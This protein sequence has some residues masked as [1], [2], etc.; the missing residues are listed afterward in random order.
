[1]LGFTDTKPLEPF[2]DLLKEAKEQAD[3]CREDHP[4]AVEK[5]AQLNQMTAEIR[6]IASDWLLDL[7]VFDEF[8]KRINL[9][10]WG[11]NND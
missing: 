4:K 1:M 2:V 10:A 11:E 7:D 8:S 5:A 3:A 6:A 9:I